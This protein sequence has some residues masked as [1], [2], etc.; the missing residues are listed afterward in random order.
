MSA[1]EKEVGGQHYKAMGVQPWDAMRGCMTPEA[2]DGYL[3]GSALS[4]LM[5]G[6]ELDLEKAIHCLEKLREV[7]HARD[8]SSA[9][10]GK[11]PPYIPGDH[12]GASYLPEY[13]GKVKASIANPS[14][15]PYDV[16][17]GVGL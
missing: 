5:R 6:K 8:C 16:E 17:L 12:G 14:H 13:F 9:L 10:E 4:Y 7:R 15:T 2:F 3:R 11:T 1:N